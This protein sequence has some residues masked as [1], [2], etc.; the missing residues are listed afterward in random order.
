M[1]KCLELIDSLDLLTEDGIIIAEHGVRD[2][3][4]D[5]IGR[6][7]KVKERNTVRFWSA[8]TD[9]Q[10]RMRNDKKRA[11]YTGSF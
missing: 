3:V 2:Q 7:T 4:P 5:Q 1:K 8:F 6:L 9:A 10:R 11:L